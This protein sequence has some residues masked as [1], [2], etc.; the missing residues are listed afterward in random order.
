M[1]VA[2]SPDVI[3]RA[4]EEVMGKTKV[5]LDFDLLTTAREPG[6]TFGD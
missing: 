6:V 3:A 2:H 1:M 4:L 5:P